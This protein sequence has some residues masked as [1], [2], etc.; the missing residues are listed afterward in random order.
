MVLTALAT[1]L[2]A[3]GPQHPVSADEDERQLPGDCSDGELVVYDGFDRFKC[4]S[5]FEALHLSNCDSGDFV[6]VEYGSLKCISREETASASHALL[7]SCSSGETLVSE[8]FGEWDC[9]SRDS[10][11][12][13]VLPS[14][15][16]G[17]ILVSE[18]SSGWRCASRN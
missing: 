7:P 1:L 2:L 11:A 16:S 18:G 4:V 17:E 14:C 13:A 12:R 8:G 10:A 6:T 3:G 15:S 9:A 5:P